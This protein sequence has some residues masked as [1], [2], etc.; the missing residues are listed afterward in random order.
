MNSQVLTAP[1]IFAGLSRGQFLSKTGSCKTWDSKADGYCRADGVGSIVL[2]RL[3]DA[4]ADKDNILGTVLGAATNH[5][6]DAVSITHPHAGNQSYLYEGV[7]H[8]AGINPLDVSFVELHGTGTQAGDLT[9]MRS[10]TDVFAPKEH[11]RSRDQPLYIGAIK[12][13]VGHGE[14]AAGVSALIKLLLMFQKHSIPPHVGIQNEVNPGF[15]NLEERNV[16]IPF[17]KASW[18]TSAGT[19]RLAFLNNFSAAGGN[20]AMLLQERPPRMVPLDIDPRHVLPFVISSKSRSS[21]QRNIQELASFTEQAPAASFASLSYTLTSRRMHH[22]YRVGL[23]ASNL[24]ALR[25]SLLAML[26]EPDF[27]PISSTSPE[28]V[29]VFTG[30]GAFYQGLGK[31]LYELSPVFRSE[32]ER[33]NGLATAQRFPSF[34]PAIEGG[35]NEGDRLAPLVTQLALVC[36]QMALV[37]LWQSYGIR[38]SAVIGHSVG[39]FAALNAAGVLSSDDTIHLVGSR[40][41]LLQEKC[42]AGT[43]AMVAVK[44]SLTE[45][46][47]V[48]KGLHFEVACLNTPTDT[49]LSAPLDDIK[50]LSHVLNQA[51][52]KNTILNLPYAFHSAQMDDILEDLENVA[53]GAIFNRPNIP[54]ISPLLG[55]VVT[56]DEVFSPAYICRHARETVDFSGAVQAAVENDTIKT[57]AVFV[58]LGPHPVCSN[59]IKAILMTEVC[60]LPSLRKRESAWKTV[61]ESLCSLHCAGLQVD[62][63]QFHQGFESSHELLNLPTY[64]F[65]NKNY[66]ID[67]TNDWCLYKIEPRN[68]APDTTAGPVSEISTLSTS[69]VHRV[70]SE[71]FDD[72]TGTMIIQSDLAHPVLRAAVAGHVVNGASLCPSVSTRSSIEAVVVE[73]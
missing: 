48:G 47:T 10:V 54:V 7:M 4:I 39:E 43:H 56:T 65:D 11:G 70:L 42:A 52:Y 8:S 51:G 36:I 49:V 37:K 66:W 9:E 64:R 18:E 62:W 3:K 63:R 22:S 26:N 45:I 41:Q 55:Q 28:V 72:D 33:L 73:Y 60:T 14:A 50:K 25:S 31:D 19:P 30:Q 27:A 13:N 24:P 71:E 1:D 44:A 29:F 61:S 69:S 20:T 12:A 34:L 38:P 59:M 15:P 6:A 21:L 17:E 35:M 68:P 40:A 5:S 46:T 23:A 58:E 57:K 53:S 2:K 16:R 67:Y 32:L